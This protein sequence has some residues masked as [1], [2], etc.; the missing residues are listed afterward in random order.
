MRHGTLPRSRT[1]G[2]KSSYRQARV[3]AIVALPA[4]Q[5]LIRGSIRQVAVF[6][7][8]AGGEELGVEKSGASGATHE[9]V[10][11]Q[12]ELYVEQGTFADAA[13]DGGH[14]VSGVD[15]TAG[16]GTVFFVEDNDRMTQG[17]GERGELGINFEIAQGFANF[18]E[19]SDFFQADG[20]AF[21]VAV[22]DRH[23]IAVGTEAE[24]GVHEARAIPLAE[25]LLRFGLH[26]FFFAADEG[27]DVALDVHRSDAGITGA[28]DGLKSDNKDFLEA[29]GVGERFQYQNKTGGG[30]VRIGDDETGVVTAIFLLQGNGVEM[31]GVDF[32]NKQRNVGIH[33]VIPR[34]ADD[35]IAGAG[36]IFFGGAGNRRIERGENE[37]AIEIGFEPL[38]D[39]SAGGIGD[40]RFEMPLDRFSVGPAGRTLGGSDFGEG[41]PRMIGQQIHEALADDARG[42]QDAGA[43][44]FPSALY[45]GAF[46]SYRRR[47]RWLIR[48]HV[49]VT[50]L[51]R[52]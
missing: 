31:R 3:E 34:V 26:F 40:R 24:A 39:E 36:E 47:L 5:G 29:E 41:K 1:F 8:A 7:E 50:S 38:D 48:L 25:E 21:E 2:G 16:L 23:A 11:E 14:A 46:Y 44:L 30:T 51:E 28:G 37:V 33:A 45:G 52:L 22:D 12:R 35:G 18:V 9:I 42:A 20:N 10:R 6:E 15:V 32:G 27:N 43:P 19:R 49:G 17:A 13:D 4:S